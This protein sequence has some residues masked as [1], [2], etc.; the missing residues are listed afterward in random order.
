MEITVVKEFRFE[1]AHFLPGYLGLCQDL[2][3]HSYRL[4]VGITGQPDSKTG[5]VLDFNE[6]KKQI[7]RRIVVFLDHRCLNEQ[8]LGI[9]PPFPHH[10]PTAENMV[11]WI[12]ERLENSPMFGHT[13]DNPRLSFV[14]LWETEGSYAEWR[15]EPC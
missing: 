9:S 11:A 15:R 13:R 1:A 12:V 7:N 5:M 14:R 6:L 8:I 10:M 3:G 2:H 4:Q